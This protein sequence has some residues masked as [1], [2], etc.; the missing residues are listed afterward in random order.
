MAIST[1][2]LVANIYANGEVTGGVTEATNT[3]QQY[4]YSFTATDTNTQ[5]SFLFRQDPAY[6]YFDDV[7]VK[8]AGSSTNLV[9]NPGFENGSVSGNANQPVN[10]SLIG[11]AGLNAAGVLSSSGAHTGTGDWYDGAV[12][13]FDGLAQTITTV[14]GTTYTLSFWL[15]T[16]SA[17]SGTQAPSTSPD[18]SSSVEQFLVYA[19]ALP[20]GLTVTPPTPPPSA[21]T[22]GTIDGSTTA[23]TDANNRPV[24]TGVASSSTPTGSTVTLYADGTQIGTTV[25]TD[26]AGDWMFTPT[27]ALADG[28]HAISATET[29]TSTGTSSQSASYNIDITTAPVVSG[30][31]GA[32]NH[33]DHNSRPAI[34]GAAAAS[35]PTGTTVTVYADGT[36]LGSTSTTDAA[37]H[38]SFTP[39]S[40]LS[41]GSHSITATETVG[42]VQSDLSASYALDIEPVPPPMALT[43]APAS[44]TGA[45]GDDR[46][47]ITTPAITGTA[48]A[49]DTVTLYD[50]VRPPWAAP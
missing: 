39:S 17:L 12:D 38:W 1:T 42:A 20:G 45:L 41:Y 13:G 4:T 36:Q 11:T 29:V 14:P 44:D 19:G 15:K 3:W 46:T 34:S 31:D 28:A 6:W 9:T 8:A 16:T 2:G 18:S 50:G 35:T 30:V 26:S 33:T 25:T 27:T 5:L 23:T 10:W 24:I 32:G 48:T 43:L 22:V 49:G 21:P 7:S 47:R 37:G 40:A